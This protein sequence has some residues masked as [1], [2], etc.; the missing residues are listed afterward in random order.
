LHG[1]VQCAQTPTATAIPEATAALVAGLFDDG[2]VYQFIGDVLFDQ[3]RDEDFVDLYPKGGQ[4]GLSPVLLAFVTV[5]QYLENLP[6]RKA[7]RRSKST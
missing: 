7:A 3:F 4:P 6:D 1:G 2:E 5:F